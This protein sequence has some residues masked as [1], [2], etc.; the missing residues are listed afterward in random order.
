MSAREV[1]VDPEFRHL[2][3]TRLAERWA[4][5]SF[6][7]KADPVIYCTQKFEMYR[8]AGKSIDPWVRGSIL[9]AVEYEYRVIR[10]F[11]A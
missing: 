11:L 5:E 10:D 3:L 9:T 1:N 7:T 4:L 6:I 8:R 2:L